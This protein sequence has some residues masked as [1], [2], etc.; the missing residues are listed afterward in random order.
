MG[1]ER[2]SHIEAELKGLGSPRVAPDDDRDLLTWD[3]IRELRRAGLTIGSHA[4]VHSPLTDFGA[5][6]LLEHLRTSRSALESALGTA[7]YPLAYPYGAWSVAVAAAARAA[8]YA[9]GLTTDPGLNSPDADAFT[10]RRFLVGADDDIVRLR[11]SLVGLRGLRRSR[12]SDR[13]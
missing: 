1:A 6:G 7:D 10:L 13:P 8:G 12:R 3:E 9:C 5:T 2:Q 11:A 4:H